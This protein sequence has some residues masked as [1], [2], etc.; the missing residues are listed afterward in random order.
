MATSPRPTSPRTTPPGSTV[1]V[2]SNGPSVTGTPGRV[3]LGKDMPDLPNSTDAPTLHAARST[4]SA[5]GRSWMDEKRKNIAAYEYL[6]RIGEAKQ[7]I[8]ACI[9][10]ELPPTTQLDEG[11]RN[12]VVLAKLARAFDP[13][14]VRRIFEDPKLQFRHSDNINYCFQFMAKVGLPT[15]FTFELTD[16]YDLKNFP[17]VVYAIHAL[18]HLLAK[19]GIAPKINNLVG[20]L[21]F[22]DAEVDAMQENL[23]NSGI[24]L[25]SFGNVN[26]TLEKEMAPT[27][28]PEEL[29]AEYLAEHTPEIVKCQS[30]A[31]R[32]LAARRVA[33]LRAERERVR[34]EQELARRREEERVA[35]LRRQQEVET[36]AAV[37]IQSVLRGHL[38]RK[39]VGAL[40]RELVRITPAIVKFQAH[41]RGFLARKHA[42]SRRNFYAKNEEAIV[43]IQSWMRS[44]KQHS[45][46][47]ALL[48]NDNPPLPVVTKFIHLLDVGAH[49]LEDELAVENMKQ[50]AVKQI[51]EN[52]ALEQHLNDLDIKIALL[53]KNRTTLDEVVKVS[54]KKL[55]KTLSDEEIKKAAQVFSLKSLDKQSRTKLE[56]YQN[57]FYL[58]QTQPQYLTKLLWVMRNWSSEV[59]KRLVETCVLTLFS[60]AQNARE[61]YLLLKLLD[62]AIE[63]EVGDVVEMGDFVK[64]NPSFIKLVLQYVRGAKERQFLKSVLQPAVEKVCR[65]PLDLETDPIQVYKQLIK[66]EESSTGHKSAKRYEVT[67]EEALKDKATVERIQRNYETLETFVQDMLGSITNS[68][69]RMPYGIRFIAKQLY[70]A[71]VVKFPKEKP[72][73]TL[74]VVGNLIYY[75][76]MNPAIVAPDAFDVSS[77]PI[78]PLNR[79]N[80]SEVSKM[81]NVIATG[82]QVDGHLAMASKYIESASTAFLKFLQQVMAVPAPE[83]HL[84]VD[85]YSDATRT[86]KPVIYISANEIFFMHST[87]HQHADEVCGGAEDPMR[88]VLETL[89]TPPGYQQ[90]KT[91]PEISLSLTPTYAGSESGG[92]ADYEL[93]RLFV[94]TKKEVILVIRAQPYGANLLDV[95]ESHVTDRDEARFDML[96]GEAAPLYASMASLASS[97]PTI[98][99]AGRNGSSPT[100]ASEPPASL[101]QLKRHVLESMAKLES[102]GLV[103]R[104]DKYQSMLSSIVQDVRN[105]HKRR[106]Q[107]QLEKAALEA[108]LTTLDDKNKFLVDQEKSYADYINMCIQQLTA[109]QGAKKRRTLPFSRHARH[110][111]DLEKQNKAVPKF[112]S[113]KYN[114]RELIDRGVVVSIDVDNFPAKLYDRLNI[115]LSSNEQGVFDI[116]TSFNAIGLPVATEHD[117][118]KLEDLLALQ[119]ENKT[120]I[121]MFEGA[122]TVNVNLL[123]YFI[124]KKV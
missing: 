83:T 81:L 31:R 73:N 74:R 41:A 77:D 13:D 65:C 48:A 24:A 102:A 43:A 121:Q 103:T 53:V 61:E 32:H 72:E 51:R 84:N 59:V 28:T 21:D 86:T 96:Q 47:S 78:S 17:K 1:N 38:A 101:L 34:R 19:K 80:L 22:T 56:A 82:K 117:S 64:G 119:F 116:E 50:H 9:Q 107:V 27:K 75:R 33:G 3:R 79:K 2:Y 94:A 76:Y 120:E 44:K 6:C 60:F 25:P 29:R 123:I 10:E 105:K 114:A 66:E 11:L 106:Q 14:L 87:L 68:L 67:R 12:G 115:T 57:M 16:L 23:D 109:H 49:D 54:S 88:T 69:G 58:L 100:V 85:G 36:P 122:V 30:A 39:Q 91:G 111:R 40:R 98:A 97:S 20:K 71:L 15:C 104:K 4:D 124:N 46:Y 45:A 8:E 55:K 89:G 112:G 70:G 26:K 52:A 63:I 110:V 95:L 7:W 113:Y 118:I 92:A 108:T 93:R 99:S 5:N 35:R 37:C 18:S 90:D 62:S 42:Q